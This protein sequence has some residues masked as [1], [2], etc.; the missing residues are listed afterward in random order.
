MGTAESALQSLIRR[1]AG[2]YT[3]GPA[4]KDAQAVCE[5]LARDGIANTVCYWDIYADQPTRICAA[6]ANLLKTVSTATSDCYLSI[7][8][9]ALRFDAGLVRKI[10]GEA[11]RLNAVVHF[12]AMGPDTV[13]R[14]F[15]LISETA[16]TYPRLGCTLPGRWRRS[17]VDAE[18]ALAMGLRV[19]VV[20]GEWPGIG[21]DEADPREG[22]LRIVEKL[23]GRA[24]HVA[25]ATHNPVMARL[26]LR[27]L[28]D[29]GT[30]C[31]I[32]LLYGLPQQPMLRIAR[33]FGVRARMYV[34]YGHAGLPY[35][36][37]NGFRNPRIIGW[38]LRDLWRC[39]RPV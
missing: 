33:D 30:P 14:T 3:A 23:A 26:A 10:L 11:A 21:G 17:A 38:F 13:D 24:V 18:R 25:V 36:L 34:P 39:K 29:A 8:A 31:E 37:K 28:Q 27:R 22:F 32:E 12:D 15:A 4:T 5:R 16:K 7:K 20:K 6:Y 1:A 2:A 9:P 35:R 19:R